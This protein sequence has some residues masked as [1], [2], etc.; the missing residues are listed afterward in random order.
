MGELIQSKVQ[1]AGITAADQF[2][3]WI[4]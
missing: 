3:G 1:A 4:R 2:S